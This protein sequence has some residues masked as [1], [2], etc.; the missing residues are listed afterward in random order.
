MKLKMFMAGL[1]LLL[2]ASCGTPKNVLYFQGMDK[3]SDAQLAK[4]NQTYTSRICP[5]DLLAIT[6]TAWDPTVVTPFNPPAWSY[7]AVQG[8]AGTAAT[9]PQLHTYPVD[10][11]GYI[12]FPVIGRIHVAGL[13]QQGLEEDLRQK[14]AHYVKDALVNVQIVNY[15]VTVLGEVSRP[16]VQTVRNERLTVLEAIGQAGDLTINANR[17]DILVIRE[18]NGKKEHGYINLTDPK[19]FASPYYYLRQNDVVYVSPNKAKQKN[20]RYSS[21]ESFTLSI[22]TAIISGLSTVT[23]IIL[24]IAKS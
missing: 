9:A 6:V 12:V 1:A 23:A 7:T 14:I 10:N 22:I 3:L 24:A 2:L 18:E 21:G 19:L 20:A 11:E 15:K 17:T 4:M 16:G 8:D 5:D 13:S